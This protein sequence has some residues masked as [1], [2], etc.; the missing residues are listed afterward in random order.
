MEIKTLKYITISDF[1]SSS[2]EEL[3]LFNSTEWDF[4]FGTND[5]S[6]ISK[7]RFIY[8]LFTLKEYSI[9]M[10]QTHRIELL[11]EKALSLPD[12][13]YIDLEN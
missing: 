5:Y 4:C 13:V 8:S 6:L 3:K 7:T 11:I 12:D 1:F 10:F 2:K 9:N